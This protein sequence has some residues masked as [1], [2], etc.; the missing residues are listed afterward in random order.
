[1]LELVGS[2]PGLWVDYD[3]GEFYPPPWT[4]DYMAKQLTLFIDNFSK[5]RLK[6]LQE[7]ITTLRPVQ[8]KPITNRP[9]RRFTSKQSGEKIPYDE[10]SSPSFNRRHVGVGLTIVGAGAVAGGLITATVS[11]TIAGA[12]VAV[13]GVAVAAT[14]PVK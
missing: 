11:L 8:S 12:V 6:H 14:T 2:I 7:V 4:D 1:M 5:E 13:A 9:P 10:K 3:N